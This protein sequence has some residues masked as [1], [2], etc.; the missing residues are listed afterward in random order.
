MKRELPEL[1][2]LAGKK[3]LL[4]GR[5]GDGGEPPVA[6]SL[7]DARQQMQCATQNNHLG[8]LEKFCAVSPVSTCINQLLCVIINKTLIYRVLKSKCD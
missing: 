5:S 1:L 2:E 6:T 3:K 7:N 8:G 4:L